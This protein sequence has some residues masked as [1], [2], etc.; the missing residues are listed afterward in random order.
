MN[1]ALAEPAVNGNGTQPQP[2]VVQ[3][4]SAVM[5]DVGGIA[6][7]DRNT[8][9]NFN[10]R[11]IDAVVNAVGPA[12]R[13]HGVVI[14]PV[15]EDAH[16]ESFTTKGRDGKPGTPMRSVT[17][18][19]RWGLYGPAGDHIEAVTYGEA[20]D[21]GDKAVPKAHSVAYR[22]L[23][24][25]AL[26]IPTDEPDPDSQSYERVAAPPSA[27]SIRARIAK[28]GETKGM[29]RDEIASDFHGWSQGEDIRV[30]EPEALLMY[31]DYLNGTPA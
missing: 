31:L 5:T 30:A 24:L 17:L 9:Q 3:A 1:T 28:L 19:I 29:A 12:L 21:A 23:L 6:K 15:A 13:Q 16:Y 26:C 2:N 22:T 27:G 10:F 7:K 25:Q 14:V 4:L 18:R 11:G 20:A 8:A